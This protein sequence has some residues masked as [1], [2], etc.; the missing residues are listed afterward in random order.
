LLWSSPGFIRVTYDGQLSSWGSNMTL[1]P[2][3][4]HYNGYKA[5][6]LDSKNRLI[7]ALTTHNSSL[8]LRAYDQ[9]GVADPRALRAV[10]RRSV[11]VM[12][13]VFATGAAVLG[14]RSWRA[15]SR[16]LRSSSIR[17]LEATTDTTHLTGS[18]R[19]GS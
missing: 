4:P 18:P 16:T 1:Y 13:A 11:I 2:E 7:V 19:S 3:V 9:D 17:G 10:M 12:I 15:G 6:T 8:V 5:L 14:A